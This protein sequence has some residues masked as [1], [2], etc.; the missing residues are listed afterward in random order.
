METATKQVVKV[1]DIFYA[2]WGYEQT[3]VQF[4]KVV[5]A[6]EKTVWV[7]ELMQVVIEQTSWASET[8]RAGLEPKQT[9][10][11]YDEETGQAIWEEAPITRH[12]IQWS[13]DYVYIKM[14]SYKFANLWD[15]KDKLAT[16]WG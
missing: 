4:Y 15:G 1:G 7:Q 9:W 12:R 2:S 8:V 6:T 3:N 11:G 16:N 14:N 5:R 13:G 10:K